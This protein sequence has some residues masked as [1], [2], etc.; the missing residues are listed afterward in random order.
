MGLDGSEK[1]DIGCGD[2]LNFVIEGDWIYY[3]ET[4]EVQDFSQR[5]IFDT[6]AG[7]KNNREKAGSICK[8]KISGQNRTLIN[9]CASTDL[10]KSGDFLYYVNYDDGGKIYSIKVDG[11]Q[12]IKINNEHSCCHYANEEWVFY[13][14]VEDDNKLYRIKVD[15]TMRAVVEYDLNT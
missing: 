10:C 12:N 15:G 8:M 1:S 9:D 13:S 11:S 14:S 7:R 2:S 3:V 4:N 5:K 6:L